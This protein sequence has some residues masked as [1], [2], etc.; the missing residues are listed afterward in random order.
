M[1]RKVC[2]HGQ[3]HPCVY[4]QQNRIAELERRCAELQEEL[5][6]R[7]IHSCGTHC[8]RVECVLR[9]ERDEALR[10]LSIAFEAHNDGHGLSGDEIDDI[11]AA[12]ERRA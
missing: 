1:G 10:L 2:A 6:G 4:C 12:L 8:Q 7:G 3:L 9:R 11:H 5:A